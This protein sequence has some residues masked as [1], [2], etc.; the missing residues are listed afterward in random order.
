MI[1]EENKER[2]AE[3]TAGGV[4]EYK[5][6]RLAAALLRPLGEEGFF[7]DML[8]AGEEADNETYREVF[9]T[10]FTSMGHRRHYQMMMGGPGMEE[11]DQG[12]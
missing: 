10:I 5:K 2:F 9:Q 4:K 3:E 11:I 8:A 6:Y 12:P 1:L 7:G